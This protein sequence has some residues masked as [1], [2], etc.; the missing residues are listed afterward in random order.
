MKSYGDDV[1]VVVVELA[2]LVLSR[3][4]AWRCLRRARFS[5]AVVIR[6]DSNVSTPA[7]IVVLQT[8]LNPSGSLGFEVP[9]VSSKFFCQFYRGPEFF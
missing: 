6:E 9:C 4:F 7:K 8:F 3:L 1:V 2:V 5:M